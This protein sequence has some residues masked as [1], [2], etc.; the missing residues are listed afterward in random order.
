MLTQH[1]G[2]LPYAY[3]MPSVIDLLQHPSF[4]ELV[5][6]DSNEDI[7]AVKWL[8]AVPL[9]PKIVSDYAM[10]LFA[11]AN[12]KAYATM[13]ELKNDTQSEDS[14]Y[15]FDVS[16]MVSVFDA[17]STTSVNESSLCTMAFSFF[18]VKKVWFP[19]PLPFDST[20]A[21][22]RTHFKAYNRWLES[23]SMNLPWDGAGIH[24]EKGAMAVAIELLTALGMKWETTTTKE[25]LLMGP[26]FACARC[27]SVST[28]MTW[29]KLVCHMFC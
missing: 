15:S 21:Q 6:D 16:E 27:P 29:S 5:D 1:V 24:A 28:L 12:T 26:C 8:A 14:K 2:L 22:V 18:T 23:Y 13:K 20:V 10:G 17:A 3:A 19:E 25:L 11:A 4:K 9:V 7:S